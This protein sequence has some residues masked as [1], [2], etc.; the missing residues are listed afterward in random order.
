MRMVSYSRV[1]MNVYINVHQYCTLTDAMNSSV[2]QHLTAR[3]QTSGLR[4]NFKIRSFSYIK[5]LNWM[6]VGGLIKLES[7]LP[8]SKTTASARCANSSARTG[9]KL[10]LLTTFTAMRSCSLLRHQLAV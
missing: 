3:K 2:R 7:V 1:K 9:T 8:A 10:S 4:I 6:T 5:S